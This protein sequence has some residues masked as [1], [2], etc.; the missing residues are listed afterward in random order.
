MLV[1]SNTF[2][3]TAM[4]VLTLSE[5]LKVANMTLLSSSSNNNNSNHN[6]HHNEYPIYEY[7]QFIS[8]LGSRIRR[9]E[10]DCIHIFNQLFEL[11]LQ[12]YTTL[13]RKLR[14]QQQQEQVSLTAVDAS[15]QVETKQHDDHN[16]D[17]GEHDEGA[18]NDNKQPTDCKDDDDNNE[19]DIDTVYLL[20]IGN[21]IRS[22]MMIGHERDVELIFIKIVIQPIYKQYLIPRLIDEHGTRGECKNLLY[23]ITTMID[24]IKSLYRPLLIHTELMLTTTATT[25]TNAVDVDL[26]TNGIWVPFINTLM[27]DVSLRMSIFSPGIANILQANYTILVDHCLVQF[28][29]QLLVNSDTDTNEN[30]ST[31]KQRKSSKYDKYMYMN[32]QSSI[33]LSKPQINQIQE[34]IYQH[35]STNE[36]MKRWNL[37]IY[38][39]LRFGECCTRINTIIDITKKYGW[40]VTAATITNTDIDLSERE[41]KYTSIRQSTGLELLLF[42]ELYD[43]ITFLWQPNI[44]I[45][46]LTNRFLR[47]IL[48][49]I[50]RVVSFIKDGLDGKILFGNEESI[51]EENAI[52]NDNTDNINNNNTSSANDS[53]TV[54]NATDITTKPPPLIMSRK[55]Y[56][57]G[58]SESDVA[59]VMWE[60]S[61]LESIIHTDYVTT[62]CDAISSQSSIDDENDD[63]T[64]TNTA[65]N[66]SRSEL[67]ELVRDVL[68]E[69]SELISPIIDY[70]WNALIVNMIISKCSLPISAVKGVAATYRM[71]NRPPPT[72]SSPF[73]ITILRPL[74][75]FDTEFNNRVPQKIGISWKHNIVSS[76]SDKYALAVD[77]LITTVQRAEESLMKRKGR[78]ATIASN[79][80]SGNAIS[81]SDGEKVKLQLYLDY[82]TYIRSVQEVGI[83]PFTIDGIIKLGTLTKEGETILQM[84]QKK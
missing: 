43:T 25:T 84:I 6:H 16:N 62:V 35:P 38:Y 63:T 18:S 61:I 17:G 54:L 14:Q 47:G 40:S 11:I 5:T 41:Q 81:M 60:L 53:T 58:E 73:V 31:T 30:Y 39:Q 15:K 65:K 76:I 75:E 59:S 33:V 66:S 57:W 20:V 32:H 69:A 80:R 68:V 71:T 22:L 77:D 24:E 37:P 45:K 44:I 46:P 29:R 72:M 7:E 26:I 56:S 49:I 79:I 4:M 36:F 64:A 52:S 34:R 13:R 3:R 21:L 9:I 8:K 55:P 82:Q 1:Y 10:N 27:N 28:A 51:V 70:G 50:G 67:K 12:E 48:Q 2:E 42:M 83:D 19:N 74:R 78:A 23:V